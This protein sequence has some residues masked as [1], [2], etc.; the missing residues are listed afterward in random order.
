M[1]LAISSWVVAILKKYSRFACYAMSA[2]FEP[3]LGYNGD[4]QSLNMYPYIYKSWKVSPLSFESQS[5]AMLPVKLLSLI[6][7]FCI[8]MLLRL[9]AWDTQSAL[10]DA[11]AIWKSPGGLPVNKMV[12]S[13]LPSVSGKAGEAPV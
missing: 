9:A 3:L 13:R 12:I 2:K 8:R 4:R 7:P 10:V 5:P 6:L 1:S 11:P